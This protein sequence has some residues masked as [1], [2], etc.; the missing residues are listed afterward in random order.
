MDNAGINYTII[1]VVLEHLILYILT[2]S[3]FYV[4]LYFIQF[5]LFS[6]YL[7]EWNQVYKNVT[8]LYV[9]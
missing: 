7:F 4:Y 2:H 9:V 5:S 6:F 3:N 1:S 8:A